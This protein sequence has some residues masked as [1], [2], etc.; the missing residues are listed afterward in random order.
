M[1]TTVQ[2]CCERVQRPEMEAKVTLVSSHTHPHP[3]KAAAMDL[4]GD[5]QICPIGLI[6]FQ[7]ACREGE[8]DTGQIT[9]ETPGK[10]CQRQ[11]GAQREK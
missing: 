8:P 5:T 3:H 1:A 7:G 11:T 4:S 9:A 6:G 2:V 10:T